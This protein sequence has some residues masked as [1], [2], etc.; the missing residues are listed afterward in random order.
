MTGSPQPKASQHAR[1]S[2]GP[3][4]SAPPSAQLFPVFKTLTSPTDRNRRDFGWGVVLFAGQSGDSHD[5]IWALLSSPPAPG[6]HTFLP[7]P[8]IYL[9]QLHSCWNPLKFRLLRWHK[10]D[11]RFPTLC[12]YLVIVPVHVTRTPMRS[13][14]PVS[15]RRCSACPASLWISWC[16]AAFLW[17]ALRNIMNQEPWLLTISFS[18]WMQL[19]NSKSLSMSSPLKK[20]PATINVRTVVF[21][22]Q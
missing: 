3:S 18:Q 17:N 2:I 19:L 10:L 15:R 1:A 22:M 5:S 4:T 12:R 9:F 16:Q 13:A 6:V 11:P 21:T 20:W 7:Q 8:L 14:S